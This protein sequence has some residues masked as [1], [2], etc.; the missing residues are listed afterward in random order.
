M[1]NPETLSIAH[2]L[3]Y[4]RQKITK[5]KPVGEHELFSSS[6][7][8]QIVRWDLRTNNA[9]QHFKSKY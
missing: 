6:L 8:G 9:V 2:T 3:A 4:H 5:I 7:D 1:Y